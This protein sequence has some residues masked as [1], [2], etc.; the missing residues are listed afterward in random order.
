MKILIKYPSRN[1]KEKFYDTLNKMKAM[2]NNL[3]DIIFHFT[4]RGKLYVI[5]CEKQQF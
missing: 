1:R 3:N 4:I 5:Q 2:A